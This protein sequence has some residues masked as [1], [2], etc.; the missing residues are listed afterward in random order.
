MKVLSRKVLSRRVWWI[1]KRIETRKTLVLFVNVFTSPPVRT[2][3]CGTMYTLLHELFDVRSNFLRSFSQLLI[4]V[5]K[6]T[7]FIVSTEPLP[8]EVGTKSSLESNRILDLRAHNFQKKLF[9][10]NDGTR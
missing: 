3:H 7:I 5:S 1:W 10:E 6:L 9:L 2:T 8:L 4:S